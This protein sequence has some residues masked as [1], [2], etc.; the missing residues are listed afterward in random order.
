MEGAIKILKR[1]IGSTIFIVIFI[2][3]LI[4]LTADQERRDPGYREKV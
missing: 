3:L 1:F 2:L 4:L